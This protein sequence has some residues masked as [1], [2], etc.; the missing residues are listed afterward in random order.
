NLMV[1]RLLLDNPYIK[2][3]VGFANQAFDLFAPRLYA[4]YAKTM[5]DLCNWNP[6]LERHY[7]RSVFACCAWN[8]AKSV[9]TFIHTDHLNLAF[10]WCAVTALGKFDPR[11]GGHL[12]IWDLKLVIEFPPGSTIFL[13]SAILRHSNIPVRPGESRFSFTQWTAGGLFRWTDF[14][15]RSAGSFEKEV[16]KQAAEEANT[17]RWREGVSLLPRLSDLCC[18]AI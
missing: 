2:R 1:I 13:C 6:K 5:D 9:W 17:A 8:L 16:G 18:W 3:I 7:P 14:G 11:K 15:F 12:I 4:Y 10:G